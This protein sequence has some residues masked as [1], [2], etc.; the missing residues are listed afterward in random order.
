[1]VLAVGWVRLHGYDMNAAI[2]SF[3]RHERGIQAVWFGA[4]EVSVMEVRLFQSA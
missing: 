2:M 1:V 3:Q 4:A